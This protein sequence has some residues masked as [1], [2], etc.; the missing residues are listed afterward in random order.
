MMPPKSS[1]FHVLW[2]NEK[3]KLC[4]KAIGILRYIN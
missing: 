2:N 3:T 4:I 1:E